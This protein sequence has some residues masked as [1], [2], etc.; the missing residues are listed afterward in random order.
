[1]STCPLCRSNLTEE[2]SSCSFCGSGPR[3]RVKRLSEKE[4]TRLLE[5]GFQALQEQPSGLE[6][7]LARTLLKDGQEALESGDLEE[8]SRNGQ[9]LKKA[10]E[11]ARQRSTWVERIGQV[12]DRLQ[13]ASKAGIDTE[14]AESQL[15]AL[16]ERATQGVFKGMSKDLASVLKEVDPSG[17]IQRVRKSIA[18]A[19]KRISYARERGG[20]ISKALDFLES[21]EKAIADGNVPLASELIRRATRAAEYAR[22][23]ARAHQLITNVE[24]ALQTAANR[25]ADVEEGRELLEKARKALKSGVYADVQSWTKAARDF[26]ERARRRKVAEDAIRS[27]ERLLEDEAGQGS[28]LPGVARHLEEAWKA[29]E[30]GKF[31]VV[32]K[33]LSACRKIADEAARHRKALEAVELLRSELEELRSMEADV[34][35][36]DVSV[37]KAETAIETGDWKAFRRHLQA[38][39]RAARKA[40]KEREREYIFTTVEKIVDQAGKGGVS[41]LGAR[42]LLAE[43]ERALGQG[44]HTD[45][46]DLVEAKFEAEATKKEN[47]FILAVGELRTL[48]AEFRVAGTEVSAASGLL[49]RA[50]AALEAKEL[51]QAQEFLDKAQEVTEALK[52]ALGGSAERSLR[53]LEKDILELRSLEIQAPEA[54]EFLERGRR[55][56]DDGNAFEAMDM[57][58]LAREVC[59]EAREARLGKRIPSSLMEGLTEEVARE[60][61][62]HSRELVAVLERTGIPA[63]ALEDSVERADGALKS[64]DMESLGLAIRVLEKIEE[65]LRAS[66]RS[67]LNARMERLEKLISIYETPKAIKAEDLEEVRRAIDNDELES[68][69]ETYLTLE[70]KA[71]E[72]EERRARELDEKIADAERR[73]T[74]I[75]RVMEDLQ[76][77]DIAI[78]GADEDLRMVEEALHGK[79]LEVAETRISSLEDVAG[80]LTSG[81]EVAAKDL[82]KKTGHLIRE[83]KG[84]GLSVPRGE[85]VLNTAREALKEGRY[86]EALEYSKVIEDIVERTRLRSAMGNL[87]EYM[88]SLREDVERLKSGGVSMTRTEELLDDVQAALSHGELGVAKLMIDSLGKPLKDLKPEG[89]RPEV[90]QKAEDLLPSLEETKDVLIQ[91]EEML[92]TGSHEEIKAAIGNA[93]LRL[94]GGPTTLEPLLK[95][96]KG[97]VELAESLGA[98]VSEAKGI[99]EVAEASLG[100]DSEASLKS[101]EDA[102]RALRESIKDVKGDVVPDITLDLPEEGLTEGEWTRY[103]FYIRNAGKVPARQVRLRLRGDFDSKGLETIPEL[104]PGESRGIDVSIRPWADGDIPIDVEVAYRRYF[105]DVEERTAHEGKVTA[106]PVGTYLV[107]DVFLVHIDGR[108]I[109]HQSRKTM[110]EIDE[111]I[112]SGMLTVVQ[113]FVKDSFRERTK[114]GL[115]RLEFEESKI[116]I[117]R[118]SHVYLAGVLLGREPDLLPLYMMELI[119]EIERDYNQ[120]LE[121]WTGLLSDLEGIEDTVRRLIFFAEDE[122]VRGPEGTESVIGSAISLIKGGKALGLDVGESEELLLA[123]KEAVTEDIEK[124][125]NLVQDAV[126]KALKTQQEQQKKLKAALGVLDVQLEDLAHVGL[127]ELMDLGGRYEESRNEVDKAKKALARGEYDIAARLVTSLEESVSALKERV[128]SENVEQALERIDQTLGALERAGADTAKPREI[129]NKAKSALTDGKLGEVHRHLEEAESAT[130]EMREAFLLEKYQGDLENMSRVLQEVSLTEEETK[131]IQ[132]MLDVAQ[133]A[134]SQSDLDQSELLLRKARDAI[135]A[136]EGGAGWG[137][138]PKLSVKTPTVGLQSGAWNR[139]VVEV[140]NKGDWPAVDLEVKLTGE[141]EVRGE[142]RIDKVG[143]GDAKELELGLRPKERGEASIDLEVSYKRL[144]DESSQVMRDVRD[145]AVAPARTYPVQ[146]ALLFLPSG[147]SVLHE[148][149]RSR[150]GPERD[151]FHDGLERVQEYIRSASREGKRVLIH[152]VEVAEDTFVVERGEATYLATV[153][154]GRE[155]VLLPL[156]MLDVL[157]E[158]EGLHGKELKNWKGDSEALEDLRR[159]VRKLL[160]VT[161]REKAQLGPLAVSPITTALRYGVPRDE[162]KAR[163]ETLAMDVGKAMTEGGFEKALE[164]FDAALGLAGAAAMKGAAPR[165]VSPTGYSVEVDDATLK[166]YIEVAKEIDK[167]VTKARGKAG[168]EILWP[169]PRIAIRAANPMTAAAAESFKAMI[170]SHANAKEADILEKGE[171]WKGADLKMQIHEDALAKS[172]KVWA[173]KIELIL[174]SQ[175]P[176]KIKSGID[177]GAYEMGIEGQVIQILP[178]MVS[179]QAI[180]P[181]HVVAQQFPGG[182][183]FLDTTMTE[184][185]RAEGYANEII[186]VVL[187]ARAELDLDDEQP[188]SVRIMAGA[189][190]RALLA[191]MKEYITEEV[192]A[193]TLEFVE[194]VGEPAYAVECEVG[195][196]AFTVAIDEA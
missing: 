36:T 162:R 160:L 38:S 5:E 131:E 99:L 178:G 15:A 119:N 68:A 168:V 146:D 58:R 138:G 108:L 173:K 66:L 94:G 117:E 21:A 176:W 181:P 10:L 97:Q 195:E 35:K 3:S 136:Q 102:R 196:E 113:D 50:E 63:E 116:I 175:D 180:M 59:K 95:D 53:S 147:E 2:S 77:A 158:V 54:E 163:A 72:E 193:R 188:I 110:D 84:E 24:K 7:K 14:E 126:E 60:T 55:A 23:N 90:A 182:L 78:E 171:F 143:P 96:L 184:E 43:V 22:K 106:S 172:Y 130:Q 140:V 111:D 149:R 157:K 186:R 71:E 167:A 81:L 105:D 115:K 29:V 103:H 104:A 52:E 80:S 1:M 30:D 39:N 179:F 98:D 194:D 135:L 47:K 34:E 89:A 6:L 165:P 150:E 183:V 177:K 20:D 127:S 139:C 42:E 57:A 9:A 156:Y 4:V 88:E 112:F 129:L 128:A 61:I 46:D 121:K 125:W 73:L 26:A 92:E 18:T 86:V 93:L 33:Q 91:V 76:R 45:I 159:I 190:L 83:A 107:E 187:E 28:D 69:V 67:W 151:T 32:K 82:L 144:L 185:T 51:V 142:T 145:F 12:R 85:Q 164:T 122:T 64:G 49:D 40:R 161:D 27:V 65:S 170:L 62:E 13:S 56:L 124:A 118:G 44:R 25:G 114:V 11:V 19:R 137:R 191:N 141:V 192:N 74:H 155:P 8:A 109:C 152:K 169:V 154:E 166:D 133:R 100:V 148:S 87:A 31:S 101:L 79:D 123:A 41:A 48:L 17:R 120:Q 70:G 132:R 174:R 134:V 153:V 75:R 189:G 16:D 37:E